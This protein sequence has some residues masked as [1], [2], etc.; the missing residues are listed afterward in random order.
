MCLHSISLILEFDPLKLPPLSLL[1]DDLLAILVADKRLKVT[2][3]GETE[4]LLFGGGKWW[5]VDSL[6]PPSAP[7]L[8]E[9][10]V[11]AEIEGTWRSQGR[12]QLPA[13]SLSFLVLP[14]FTSLYSLEIE[15][16]VFLLSVVSQS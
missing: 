5:D 12:D 14:E 10:N 15:A 11:F 2:G 7:V 3:E 1:W 13:L 8:L 4:A 6:P 16:G 9:E